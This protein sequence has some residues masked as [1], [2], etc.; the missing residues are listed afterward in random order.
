ME[1]VQNILLKNTAYNLVGNLNNTI[2]RLA[3]S[4]I[5]ARNLG[6]DMMGIFSIIVLMISAVEI[7]S[8]LGLQNLSTKYIA[9]FS[10]RDQ[11]ENREK[12]LFHV[13]KVKF[14]FTV[15]F[16][17]LLVIFSRHLAQFYSEPQLELY[18][19]VSAVGLLPSGL[20]M[21]MQSV[22][23]GLQKYK[24][25]AYRNLFVAPVHVAVTFLA[26]KL[27]YGIS[28]LLVANILVSVLDLAIYAYYV[29]RHVRFRFSFDVPLRK[30]IS[31]RIFRYNWQVALIVFLDTVVWQKSEV[32]FLGKLSARSEV[33][34]YSVAYNT[35]NWMVAFL[36]GVFS[37]VLF[38]AISELYGKG[39]NKSIKKIYLHS[40]RYL[41]MLAVPI[42]F[43]GLALSKRIVALLYGSEYLPMVPAF[44][45]LLLSTCFGIV[46]SAGSSVIY[47][48]EK[49]YF[50]V[51][52]GTILAIGNILM[53]L[54]LIPRYGATGAAIANSTVQVAGALVGFAMLSR[55]LDVHIPYK[56]FGKIWIASAAMFIA[57]YFVATAW[58]GMGGLLAGVAIGIVVY[59]TMLIHLGGI[60]GKDIE[61]LNGIKDKIPAFFQ[62]RFTRVL[63]YIQKHSSPDLII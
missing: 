24:I 17:L 41:M 62:T 25:I 38:P 19:I 55:F 3:I 11:A 52:V 16:S 42:C 40:T 47:A 27:H 9:E 28:G 12:L 21:I 15:V 23:Q 13:I 14:G 5:V 31:E 43:G 57:V 33:A 60:T 56:E 51:K 61:L 34:F 30:D 32:F 22:I 48:T 2:A 46:A 54:V 39:E 36:P 59:V 58:E 10:G 50:I 45:I 37:G 6:P 20:T 7:V 18:V 29:S 49:Q 53:N 35:A 26:L 63:G 44:D 1:K 4:I 8:N